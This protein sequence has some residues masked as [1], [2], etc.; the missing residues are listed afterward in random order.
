VPA[1]DVEITPELVRSLLRAQHP[2]LASLSLMPFANGW[3][4]EM[5]R[6]GDDLLVRLP[7]RAIAA[8]SIEHE[9]NW[10]PM[11]AKRCALPAELAI[12]VPVRRGSPG[13]GYPY[14]WS[15]V[16]Y[17]PGRPVG[18]AMLDDKA[19]RLLGTFVR[20]IHVPAPP[21]AP[22]NPIRGVPLADRITRFEA[23]LAIVETQGVDEVRVN[24]AWERSLA[25]PVWSGP[26][27]WLHGDLHPLN[28]LWDGQRLT[29]IIDFGDVTGGDPATDLAVAWMCFAPRERDVFLETTG[30]DAATIERGRGW[31]IAIAVAVMASDDRVIARLGE[32]TLAAALDG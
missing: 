13:E 5:M 18:D 11:I 16:P 19:A 32:H 2:D 29:G 27:L 4:N 3:D 8:E 24:A 7:R 15:I 12:P 21:E 25:A 17:A 9:C 28:I 31:A 10:V 20:E 6:L 30:A 26:P 1:A 22:S 14:P 23:A